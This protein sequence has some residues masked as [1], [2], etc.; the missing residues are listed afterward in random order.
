MIS[1]IPIQKAF[2]KILSFL[3]QHSRKD[4]EGEDLKGLTTTK[5]K[6]DDKINR[7]RFFICLECINY[8]VIF[9]HLSD[10]NA[11]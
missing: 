3:F 10:H 7:H 9:D 1:L 5:R 8:E 11:N 2:S 6:S 4:T